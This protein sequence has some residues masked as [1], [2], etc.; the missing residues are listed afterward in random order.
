M[1]L[2]EISEAMALNER[3]EASAI[4]QLNPTISG[5]A[6]K[7]SNANAIKDQTP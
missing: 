5:T 7:K 4:G 3:S 6:H 1:Y 2:N